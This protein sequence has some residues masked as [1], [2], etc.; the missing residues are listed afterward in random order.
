MTS[1][2]PNVK[3]NEGNNTEAIHIVLIKRERSTCVAIKINLC[4]YHQSF[5]VNLCDY[6]HNLKIISRV[7][8]LRSTYITITIKLMCRN[9]YTNYPLHRIFEI[10]MIFDPYLLCDLRCLQGMCTSDA[11][12]YTC[13][14]HVINAPGKSRNWKVLCYSSL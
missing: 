11:C 4:E 6:H 5:K 1:C 9:R 7:T 2:N 14:I 13:F 8:I 10:I 12:P 3:T